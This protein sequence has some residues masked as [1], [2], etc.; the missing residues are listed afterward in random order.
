MRRILQRKRYRPTKR[1]VLTL[2]A[3][4][5]LL[6]FVGI[7]LVLWSK[8]RVSA[9][10]AAIPMVATIALLRILGTGIRIRKR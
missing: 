6:T 8:G 1:L 7:G 5:S 4:F 9:G 2:A 3:V 10:Y